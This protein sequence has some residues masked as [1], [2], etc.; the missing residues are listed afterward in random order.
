MNINGHLLNAI[1][2]SIQ[3][4]QAIL[5][6]GDAAKVDGAGAPHHADDLVVLFQQELGQEAA[7]LPGD[8]RD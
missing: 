4:G 5:D 7:I 1:Q 8:A 6:V 3:A 2:T